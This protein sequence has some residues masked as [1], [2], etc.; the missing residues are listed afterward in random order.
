MRRILVCFIFWTTISFGQNLDTIKKIEISYGYGDQ[1][2]PRNG[3]YSRSEKFT[4]EKSESEIFYLTSCKKFWDKSQKKATVF[5]KDSLVKVLQKRIKSS[6]ITDLIVNVNANKENF[7]FEF[8]KSRLN[9]PTKR[10]IKK[11]ARKRDLYF[12]IECYGLFDCENRNKVINSLKH[13]EH[14]DKFVSSLNLSSNQMVVIGYSNTARITLFSEKN[15]VTYEFSFINNN[16]G[17]PILKNYNKNY[18]DRYGFVNLEANEII[19]EI[20]PR[21]SMTF[22]TF[23]LNRV[24]DDYINWYLQNYK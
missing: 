4:F 18:L 16:I 10:Q 1:C 11:I 7:S 24:T 21:K 20:I 8:L 13:F 5:S 12:K 9:E 2:F 19:Q 3:I 6:L 23:D 17:Q 14:F 15:F 22:K